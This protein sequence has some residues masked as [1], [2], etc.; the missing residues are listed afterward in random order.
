MSL[1][2]TDVRNSLESEVEGLPAI[3]KQDAYNHLLSA[4]ISTS[5]PDNLAENLKIYA[6]SLLSASVSVIASG[7]LLS[8]FISQFMQIPDPGVK[9]DVGEHLV[10]L[11]QPRV[12]SLEEQDTRIKELLADSLEELE[13]FSDA[14]KILQTINLDSS[15]RA[16]T[17]D[18]RAKHWIRIVR[19]YL[20]E[21]E[22]ADAAIYL[23][24]V[25]NDMP[26]VKDRNTRLM[27]M[28]AQARI[29]DSQR[30]FLDAS[31]K[32]YETSLETVVDESER[33]MALGQSIVCAVLA[34]AGPQRANTLA[35]LYKDDRAS[36]VE[37]YAIL[38]KIFLNRLLSPEEVKTFAQTLKT[39]QLAK[40]ADGS[41][42]LENAVLEH[43]LLAVSRFY[44]NIGIEQLGKLLG[45]N[46]E[47]AE[48]YA[49]QMI[50]QGRLAG[51]IDQIDRLIIFE[52][53]G[54]GE[55]K[56]GHADALVGREQRTWDNNVWSL[57][58]EVEKVT[59]MIQTHHPVRH[60]IAFE[61]KS[62]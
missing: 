22:T 25:K 14:A 50:E 40:M 10:A 16:V 32:Y 58:E 7:P 9:I 43:N 61:E 15:Q 57:A 39:H 53:E 28:F 49:A 6:G 19:L 30:S 44:R 27:F 45:V 4:I 1:S 31:I 56:V 34:P 54:S 12:V 41:T 8:S 18:E 55:R 26:D 5:K 29:L 13:N 21:E 59:T 20:E 48:R 42:V 33:L 60:S 2:P 17:A 37:E 23:N 36:E 51:Y 38:E 35:R 3:E 11:I 47:R 24:R 46:S 62:Y 52:G